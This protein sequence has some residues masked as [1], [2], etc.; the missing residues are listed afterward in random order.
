VAVSLIGLL[1]L[2]EYLFGLDLGIDQLLIRDPTS[3]GLKSIPGRMAFPTALDF[4][5]LG[6]ALL[7]LDVEITPGRYPAQVLILA[8]L[9]IS[10][11]LVTGYA[12][13]APSV[14]QVGTYASVALHTAVL[15]LVLSIGLLCARP[16]RGVMTI[17]SSDSI[18]GRMMRRLL[19]ASICAL[20]GLG[21]LR[22]VGQWAGFY[23]TEVGTFLLVISAMGTL[24]ALIWFNVQSLHRTDL[25]REQTENELRKSESRKGAILDSSQDGIISIDH[26]GMILEFNP[27][28]QRIFGYT[29][30]QV[31]GKEMAQLIVPPSLRERHRSG[32]V[33]YLATGQGPV[34][35][36]RIELTA[37]R[38]DGT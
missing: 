38:A 33:N 3:V 14:Y 24:S 27:A 31:L 15:L 37:L 9:F 17:V 28:A 32:L 20:F 10:I 18:S 21:W 36:Q 8:A 5:L 25:Q 29:R 30:D 2:S 13:A 11:G 26:N 23:T 6:A 16:E 35:G 22:M 12:Y 4:L 7:L 34:L 1:T 19:L